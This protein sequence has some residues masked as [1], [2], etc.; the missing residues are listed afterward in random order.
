[1]GFTGDHIVV[2]L[3]KL[4]H[5]SIVP[6]HRHHPGF[7]VFKGQGGIFN[8]FF[9]EVY[10][11]HRFVGGPIDVP[12]KPLKGIVIAMVTAGLGDIFQFHIRGLGKASLFPGSQHIRVQKISPDHRNIP[13][14]KGQIPGI[15]DGL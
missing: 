15:T 7:F 5:T 12:K 4:P 8:I 1:M 14:I 11:L 13:G 2:C 10:L 6:Q 3:I 9:K